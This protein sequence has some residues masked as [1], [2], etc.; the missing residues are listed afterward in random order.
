PD[1]TLFPYTTLFRS[2]VVMDMERCLA[3]RRFEVE[4]AERAARLVAA[5]LDRHQ[6]LEVPER[7]AA[8]GIQGE[9]LVRHQPTSCLSSMRCFLHRATEG[10]CEVRR[11][12][13]EGAGLVPDDILEFAR[14]EITPPLG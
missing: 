13:L 1:S 6:D 14:C 10:R 2:L 11:E 5:R 7:V 9:K 12:L 8:L 3:G 4:Q